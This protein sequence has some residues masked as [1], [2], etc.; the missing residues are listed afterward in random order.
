MGEWAGFSVR[1]S[2][3][4]G[5]ILDVVK[6]S[7]LPFTRNRQFPTPPSTRLRSFARRARHRLHKFASKLNQFMTVPMWSACVSIFVA[8]IPPLQAQLVR[9]K[10][11]T[12]AITS[13]GQCSSEWSRYTDVTSRLI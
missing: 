7:S 1:S 4:N 3:A 10:P 5:V 6:G 11:L 2:V 13:A 12:Q 8:M 9:A